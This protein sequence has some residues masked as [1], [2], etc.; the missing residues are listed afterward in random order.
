MEVLARRPS[1]INKQKQAQWEMATSSPGG[2][3]RGETDAQLVENLQG[4]RQVT[5]GARLQHIAALTDDHHSKQHTTFTLIYDLFSLLFTV[6]S[7]CL[8]NRLRTLGDRTHNLF[9][10]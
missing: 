5:S 6:A 1:Y 9:G 8:Q 3:G 10:C 4:M 7:A 2:Q